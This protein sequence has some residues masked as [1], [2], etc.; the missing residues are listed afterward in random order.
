MS[1]KIRAEAAEARPLVEEIAG[2]E[3]P[4]PSPAETLLALEDLAEDHGAA[5]RACMTEIDVGSQAALARFGAGPEAALR[6]IGRQMQVALDVADP[7]PVAV[8]LTALLQALAAPAR[9]PLRSRIGALWRRLFNARRGPATGPG[10]QREDLAA[11]LLAQK[12]RMLAE[13]RAMDQLYEAAL[14]H[15]DALALCIAAA[16]ERL[17]ELH[18]SPAGGESP[19]APLQADQQ[20]LALAARLAELRAVQREVMRSLPAIRQVQET[21]K[22]LVMA[23]STLLIDSL[24]GWDAGPL[25]APTEAIESAI[26]LVRTSQARRRAAGSL[27]PA[28]A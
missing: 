10:Q 3:L 25:P 21:D 5:I 16:S 2:L 11:K 12:H 27:S 23:L 20:A 14:E 13:L 18:L 7:A 24:P 17:R 8:T 6:R 28:R 26:A 19:D 22:R 9:G 15:Y 1:Q 4:E